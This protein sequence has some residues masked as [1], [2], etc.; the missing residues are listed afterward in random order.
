M[1]KL[2]SK[3]ESNKIRLLKE[4]RQGLKEVKDIQEGKAKAYSL[5]DIFKK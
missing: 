3:K 5:A 1:T 2:K 4:I